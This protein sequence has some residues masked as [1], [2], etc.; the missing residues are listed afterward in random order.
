MF[1]FKTSVPQAVFT[2]QDAQNLLNLNH[3]NIQRNIKKK[4]VGDLVDII[5][6]G[7]D[8]PA[9][10]CIAFLKHDAENTATMINGQHFCT[11]IIK[12]NKNVKANITY[13][14]CETEEDM[15][16]AYATFDSDEKKRNLNEL[17]LV[18]AKNLDFKVK[19]TNTVILMVVKA[20]IENREMSHVRKSVKA[21]V[22]KSC[23]THISFIAGMFPRTVP[24]ENKEILFHTAIFEI[25][26][27]TWTKQK[28]KSE[29]FWKAVR[30]GANLTPRDPALV[31][32]TFLAPLFWKNGRIMRFQNEIS[33]DT[34]HKK[35]IYAWNAYY[36][37]QKIKDL[38][39]H[40]SDPMPDI[41]PI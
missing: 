7:E 32:R 36:L 35:L 17:I 15:R 33:K 28:I 26:L 23:L 12:A 39:I 30:D 8:R 41:L 10:I 18:Q 20:E 21:K 31:L 34:L 2:P 11:A 27:R 40:E 38:A 16:D 3:L 37:G 13:C 22:T 5:H 24:S 19:V 6:K 9:E 29:K 25:I 4:H 1:K 14:E